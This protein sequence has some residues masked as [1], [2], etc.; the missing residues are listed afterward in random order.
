MHSTCAS[1]D[2]LANRKID[3]FH[4]IPVPDEVASIGGCGCQRD[5]IWMRKHVQVMESYT[6]ASAVQFPVRF[7]PCDTRRN[8]ANFVS[9]GLVLIPSCNENIS[10]VAQTIFIAGN[11]LERRKTKNRSYSTMVP[12]M[13]MD[14]CTPAMRSTRFS[15]TWFCES[16]SRMEGVSCIDRAGIAMVSPLR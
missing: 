12:R 6:E 9:A 4:K 11:P 5:L 1:P 16:R 15:R 2:K 7:S 8:F 13:P 3:N 14:R 10:S